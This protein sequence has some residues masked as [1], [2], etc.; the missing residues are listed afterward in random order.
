MCSKLYPPLRPVRGPELD[1]GCP[2]VVGCDNDTESGPTVF[3]RPLTLGGNLSSSYCSSCYGLPHSFLG[4]QADSAPVKR[5][6]P[7][8]CD[9]AAAVRALD[10]NTPGGP[11]S[12]PRA[13]QTQ[14]TSASRLA[15]GACSGTLR[16]ADSRHR[17]PTFRQDDG[18]AVRLSGAFQRARTERVAGAAQGLEGLSAPALVLSATRRSAAPHPGDER[19][20]GR[21]GRQA[22]LDRT[23]AARITAGP[24]SPARPP[25][26]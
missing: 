12:C 18:A 23:S 6:P 4:S 2:A 8:L 20:A 9:L 17:P 13:P 22:W 21:L 19:E 25:R 5:G 24:S 1:C 16:P 7:D 15:W 14:R 11:A 10:L 3:H 26:A